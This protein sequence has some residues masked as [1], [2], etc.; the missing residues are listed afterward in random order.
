VKIRQNTI[1]GGSLGIQVRGRPHH[2]KISKN[3]LGGST[4]PALFR[5][6]RG[7]PQGTRVTSNVA[8]EAKQL[9]RPEVRKKVNGYGNVVLTQDPEFVD[10]T[11]CDGF[12]PNL[13]ALLPYGALAP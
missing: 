3:I 9:F 5:F 7:R 11:R 12:R 8:V 13:D 10:T 6:H 1:F 2:V 4:A